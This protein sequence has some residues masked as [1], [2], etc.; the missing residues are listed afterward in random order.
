[1]GGAWELV[2]CVEV[3]EG[4]LEM[5]DCVKLDLSLLIVLPAAMSPMKVG[6]V[7]LN[8]WPIWL[9]INTTTCDMDGLEAAACVHI[10]PIS[11]TLL[12]SS[13]PILLASKLLSTNSSR[14]SFSYNLHACQLQ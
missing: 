5:D 9:L 8:F 3:D 11:I 13:S 12:I 2:D 6:F 10:N 14:E 7:S 1:M 4:P